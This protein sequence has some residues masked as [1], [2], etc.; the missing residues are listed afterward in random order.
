MHRQV[1]EF[2]YR[3]RLAPFAPPGGYAAR[4]AKACLRMWHAHKRSNWWTCRQGDCGITYLCCS[5]VPTPEMR[6]F[7]LPVP[8]TRTQVDLAAALAAEEGVVAVAPDTFRG[9]STLWP[10][11]AIAL[12]FKYALRPGASWGVEAVHETVQW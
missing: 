7:G 9:Q 11:R 4:A 6:V 5:Q 3:F 2:G 1:P 12:G 8:F 10:F